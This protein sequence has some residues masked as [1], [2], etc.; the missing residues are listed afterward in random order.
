MLSASFL[1][2]YAAIEAEAGKR[3]APNLLT[4]ETLS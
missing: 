3:I 4:P 1:E 2:E